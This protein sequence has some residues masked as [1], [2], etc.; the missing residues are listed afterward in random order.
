MKRALSV[1]NVLDAK[2]RTMPFGG[3]WLS[4]IGCPE[5][6]GSWM[7]YG[8]PK[9]GKTSCAMKLAKYLTKFGTVAYNSVEEGLKLSMKNAIVRANMREVARRFKLLDRENVEEMIE[10]LQRQKSPDIIFI[11]S[12]QFLE[13]KFSEYKRL[14]E[15]FPN[16]LFIYI[17]HI[18]GSQPDGQV[19]RRI[20]RDANVAIRV[21]GFKAFPVSRYGGGD[22]VVISPERA[23]EYWGEI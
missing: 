15:L 12:V 10:R 23:L 1:N 4:G 16:K 5:L 14:K 22:P 2:F 20:W 19:A 6:S 8:A 21:E 7:I 3:E 17:S 9:N 13:L 18:E 11:D